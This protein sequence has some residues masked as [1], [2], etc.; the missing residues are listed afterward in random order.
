ML[1][2]S[3]FNISDT[4]DYSFGYVAGWSSG[5]ELAEL[6]SSLETIRST[7]A[8]LINTIDGHI[9]EIQKEQ[10]VEQE[11]PTQEQ[12]TAPEDNT[13]SIY[14]LKGGDETRDFRFEPYDRLQAAG[15]T[16]DPANYEL[17]YTAP[18][19]NGMSLEG[20]FEKFNL[21]R[22]ADFTGHSLSV[23]D[24]VVLHQNGQDTAHYVDSFG[25]KDVPEFLKAAPDLAA[26]QPEA[27]PQKTPVT[28]YP[29]NETA[30]RRAKE[31]NSFSDYKPGSATAEYRS[32]VDEAVQLA[33]RQKARVDPMHHE[34]IDRLLDTYA[35]K[36]AENMNSSFA[37]ESRVPSILIAGGSNFPVRKKEK[38]NAARD[39][40]ME[41]WQDIKGLLEKI[42]STGMGGISAD[43]PNAIG[44]LESK[45]AGLE[46]S[47]ET[48]KAANAFYRKHKTLD[49]CPVLTAEQIQKLTADMQ[50]RW[51]G[52][53]ASQPF[54]AYAL[55][56]NNAEMNRLKK[57]I[58]EL[59]HREE[60]PLTGWEFDGGKVEINKADNRLQVFFDEKPDEE[61]RTELKKGGF[62][63]SPTA[64]AWQRQLNGNAFYAANDIKCIQPLTGERPTDLQRAHIWAEKAREQAAA[65][66]P[67]SFLTGETVQTPRGSF[68]LT[69]MSKQEMEAVGYG[70]HHQSDDGKY[71]IMGNGTQAFAI[72][73]EAFKEQTATVPTPENPLAAVE[74]TT[75]QNEN[76]IDG[77]INNTST[78]DELE[79]K[80][81]AGEQISLT[82]LAAAIKADK[83]RGGAPKEKPSIRAQLKE[84][85]E[86]AAPKKA[87][88]TKN[89]DLEV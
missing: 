20:I 22:P 86:K 73:N 23:S 35:R 3:A 44:K 68:R 65:T 27:A 7:A 29:I 47:Q 12:P 28:Y 78:V 17:T 36:L 42:R 59:T 61:K 60:T 21:D 58:T 53:A 9:A 40:N 87:A 26:E 48:M 82:D 34:K 64:G 84:G 57:R 80:V 2:I 70:F 38:Q 71:F 14:Q 31:A 56:N 79:A 43:D 74:Q 76:M 4:S 83:Q 39:R 52:R 88:K 45:L 75:E 69:S 13:F 33:E 37:I 18:L 72:Q 1:L 89:Q 10:T 19:E 41:E 8:E 11:A 85:K 5:K 77:V 25:Y 46:K 30:S 55:Q 32:M 24:V 62:R 63:W 51:Y 81:K 49:G 50:T 54:E 16:L 67:D 6:K 15:L 66:S